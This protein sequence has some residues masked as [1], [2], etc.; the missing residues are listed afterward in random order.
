MCSENRFISHKRNWHGSGT[1]IASA[2]GEEGL[3]PAGGGGI[4]CHPHMGMGTWPL[5]MGVGRAVSMAGCLGPHNC[6][7][8][9]GS[10]E[11]VF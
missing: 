4:L 11:L 8:R 6:P 2:A 9:P 7:S 5:C 1:G 3:R 10:L